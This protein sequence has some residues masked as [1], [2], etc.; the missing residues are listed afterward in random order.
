MLSMSA[1][2]IDAVLSVPKL[3]LLQHCSLSSPGIKKLK[4]F[5]SCPPGKAARETSL[6]PLCNPLGPAGSFCLR[7]LKSL[8]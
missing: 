7:A 2:R 1:L 8:P 5:K 4:N 6:Q 3:L